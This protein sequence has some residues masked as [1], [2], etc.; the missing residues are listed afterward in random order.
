M[1]V[2]AA[3]ASVAALLIGWLLRSGTLDIAALGLL[4]DEPGLLV[5]TLAVFSFGVALGALRWR[6]LLRLAGVRLPVVRALQW[7]LTAVFFNV[8][9]PGNIGGDVVKSIYVAQQAI[10][11]QRAPI[12]LIALVDRF[13]GV[14]GLIVVAV[15]ATLVRGPIVWHAPPLRQLSIA[16]GVLAIVTLVV[17]VVLLVIIR[18]TGDRFERWTIGTT[19]FASLL[20]RLVSVA[21]LVSA[22]PRRLIAALAFAI[23]VHVVGAL[24]FAALTVAVTRQ[25]VALATIAGIYPLGMLTLV[26]P[27]SPAGIGVGHVAFDHLFTIVGLRG[28]ATVF[29]VYLVSQISFCLLGAIPYVSA[30]RNASQRMA[31]ADALPI[32]PSSDVARDDSDPAR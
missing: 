24:L 22:R 5:A 23:T 16:V 4:L 19:R 3:K 26:V 29:N 10:P 27:I 21:R 18:R 14:A 30:R 1:L 2:L 32:V 20:A 31:T 7:Q 25:E 28:G 6:G 9:V 17:P 15:V 8:V 11:A 12:F 13:V